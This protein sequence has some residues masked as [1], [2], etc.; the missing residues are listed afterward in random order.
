MN[1]QS[2]ARIG[3]VLWKEWRE[4]RNNRGVWAPTL[5]L[6]IL[7]TALAV[8]AVLT[9]ANH[10]RELRAVLSG[11]DPML[12]LLHV[13]RQM[14]T[15]FLIMP[16]VLP[17]TTAA[18]SIVGEKTGRSLEP[19]LATPVQ[20]WEFLGGKM[21]A[22]VLLGVIPSWCSYGIFLS[23]LHGRLPPGIFAH[24][25]TATQLV[26]VVFIGPLLALFSVAATTMI[27]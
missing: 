17:S 21:I 24:L 18:H 3:A 14:V 1:R 4:L 23:I 26:M 10:M 27:S 9:I 22:C 7:L 5:I 13:G 15:L 2:R 6:P 11:Q 16:C 19:V 8:S 12:L 25:V 20:T